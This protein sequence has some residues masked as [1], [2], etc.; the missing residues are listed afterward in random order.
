MATRKTNKAKPTRDRI[1]GVKDWSKKFA[2]ST[3]DLR[4][5]VN[6]VWN[7]GRDFERFLQKTKR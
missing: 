5:A 1:T 4:R 7:N 3:E 2:V 6:E